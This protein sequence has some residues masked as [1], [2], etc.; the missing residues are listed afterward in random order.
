ML[1]SIETMRQSMR[2][3]DMDSMR[4]EKWKE[5]LAEQFV[6][7]LSLDPK[8]PEDRE[9]L[10]RETMKLRVLY[11]LTIAKI[12][13]VTAQLHDEHM[14]WQAELICAG[15][16]RMVARFENE[17]WAACVHGR[18]IDVVKLFGLDEI[19]PQ[20]PERTEG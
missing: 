10:R 9:R 7:I 1:Y 2:Y 5:V 13:T 4:P 19:A 18:D 11:E 12:R 3:Y 16:L 14:S 6:V 20:L 17:V 8:R 15:I